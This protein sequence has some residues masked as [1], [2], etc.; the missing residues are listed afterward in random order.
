MIALEAVRNAFKQASD[1]AAFPEQ[2][3]YL[4]LDPWGASKLYAGAEGSQPDAD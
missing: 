3:R 2:I 4:F 1:P